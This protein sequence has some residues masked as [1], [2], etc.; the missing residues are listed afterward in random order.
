MQNNVRILAHTCN[1]ATE[2]LNLNLYWHTRHV[3]KENTKGKCAYGQM[4]E[5]A[6]K[7]LK[8]L[9]WHLRNNVTVHIPIICQCAGPVGSNGY[10]VI[11]KHPELKACLLGPCY[12]NTPFINISN[13]EVNNRWAIN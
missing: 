12:Y 7:A 5:Y 10:V 11:Y 6:V 9:R 2:H 8:Y 1:H 4:H 13:Q 3:S